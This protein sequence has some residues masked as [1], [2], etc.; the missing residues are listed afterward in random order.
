MKNSATV[1]ILFLSFNLFSQEDKFFKC[2]EMKAQ[3]ID[4]NLF[5]KLSNGNLVARFDRHINNVYKIEIDNGQFYYVTRPTMKKI[6]KS[7]RKFKCKGIEIKEIDK[8]DESG[9]RIK[10][11]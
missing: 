3:I 11:D 2:D 8:L 6:R 9:I 7:I 4:D 10:R 1:L 5:D